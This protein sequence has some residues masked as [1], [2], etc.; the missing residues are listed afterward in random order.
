M[1]FVLFIFSFIKASETVDY[2]IPQFVFKGKVIQLKDIGAYD[3]IY[4]NGKEIQ[5]STLTFT[6]TGENIIKIIKAKKQFNFSIYAINGILTILPPLIAILLALIFKEVVISLFVGIFTGALLLN[7]FDLIQAFFNVIDKYIIN[8]IVD[9]N[10]A[11][12]LVFTLLLGGM[13]GIISKSGGV[14]GIV[15]SLSKRVKSERGTQ[16]YTW[17]MGILIFFDD[18]TNTLI[19]GN[20]MRPLTDKWKVSREKLSYIVDSTAAP[21][22]SIALISTWIGFEISLIDQSLKAYQIPYDAYQMFL[23]SLPYRFYPLLA[24]ILVFLIFAFKRDFGP[25][26]KAEKRARGGKLLSDRAVPLADFE[27]SGLNPSE[28]VPARWFNGMIPILVVIVFTFGG[29]YISGMA[30]LFSGGNPLAEKSFFQVLFSGSVFRDLGTV[31]SSADSFKVLLWAS[32][33]GVITALSLAFFQKILKLREA[34]S[35]LVQGMKSMMMAVVI[36][37]LA[38]SLGVVLVELTTADFLVSLLSSSLDYQLF[39]ALVFIFSALIAFSTGTSWGTIG[40]MYPLVIPIIIGLMRGLPD[41]KYFLMLTIA[42]VLAGAVFGDHCSPI[43]DTTIMSSLA[44]SCDHID[45]VKTQI[46]YALTAAMVALICGI[47]PVCFGFPYVFAILIS[48]GVLSITLVFLGKR[49]VKY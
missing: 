7:R 41:L 43:S 10:R 25:M 47:I 34:I 5:E 13:V 4:L 8:A 26:L 3:R 6:Q 33:M 30:Q 15:D 23:S 17:L 9:K 19:V 36:L 1:V 32:L 12:I 16:L 37:I 2:K 42:S 49:I 21:M 28:K 40:I 46:P 11:S 22:A 38:W 20:T 18:Y 29:L 31:I 48:I 44:S 35:A 24:L 27:S 39:P 14:K 45:H